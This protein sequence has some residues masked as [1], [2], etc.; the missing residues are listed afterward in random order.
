MKC[1][2]CVPSSCSSRVCTEDLHKTLVCNV[3]HCAT[4]QQIWTR[5]VQKNRPKIFSAESNACTTIMP[6]ARR[7]QALHFTG[8]SRLPNIKTPKPDREP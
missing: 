2:R 1:D 8:P 7:K 5:E 3:Q 6:K 4:Y